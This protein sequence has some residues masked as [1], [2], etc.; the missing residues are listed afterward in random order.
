MLTILTKSNAAA[1]DIS[2]KE[3][4]GVAA[5]LIST[6]ETTHPAPTT[7]DSR[8]EIAKGVD[9]NFVTDAEKTIIGNTTGENSGDQ[10]LSGKE[11]TGVAA[12]LI[13]THE[14]THPAPTTRDSRNEAAGVAA[15]L[16]STH[17][18]THP[19]PT[20]RDSRND[21]AG[22]ASGLMSTHETTHPAPTTRDSRN[23]VAKG[24]DDNFVTDTEK[25]AIGNLGTAS[26]SA[27]GDF[28]PAK[29]GDDNFVTDVEKTMLSEIQQFAML[30]G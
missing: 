3:N 24:A 14:T 25:T 2:G 13:F 11:N 26:A 6:H 20:T 21:A 17:E 22:V 9:D 8:N 12:G 4:V 28:E 19:S 1:V 18:T 29:G 10:D 23:E 15:G 16:V 5:G 30:Q 7:R 27:I